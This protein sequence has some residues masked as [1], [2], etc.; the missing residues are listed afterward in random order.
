MERETKSSYFGIRERRKDRLARRAKETESN[1]GCKSLCDSSFMK[2][3][4]T[5]GFLGLTVG[6]ATSKNMRLVE[7]NNLPERQG[8]VFN[9]FTSIFS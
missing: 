4:G 1:E 7:T 2:K 9:V 6:S 5:E 3:K 8:K